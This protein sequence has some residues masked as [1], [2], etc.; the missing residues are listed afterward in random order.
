MELS[1]H[2]IES[3]DSLVNGTEDSNNS[4]LVL[5][6]GFLDPRAVW[7]GQGILN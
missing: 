3:L 1:T 6:G 7:N 5:I 2:T 4:C